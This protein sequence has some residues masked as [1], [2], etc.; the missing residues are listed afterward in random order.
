[1]DQE[2]WELVEILFPHRAEALR[3]AKELLEKAVWVASHPPKIGDF[4]EDE[5]GPDKKGAGHGVRTAS[6]SD[7]V[8]TIV[9]RESFSPGDDLMLEGQASSPIG[10]RTGAPVK[11]GC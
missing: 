8:S 11:G 3:E 1:M 9:E 5:E 2:T 4:W 7:E 6:T 10:A